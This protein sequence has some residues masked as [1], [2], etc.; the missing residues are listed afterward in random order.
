MLQNGQ[1]ERVNPND[2]T[3]KDGSD[4]LFATDKN[5][6]VDKSKGSVTVMKNTPESG[7]IIS[8]L[9]ANRKDEFE[10]SVRSCI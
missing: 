9:V 8:D 7:S 4:T 1:V 3:E 5:G 6:N 10:Y 2:G